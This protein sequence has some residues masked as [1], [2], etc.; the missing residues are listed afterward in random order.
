[1]L[2]DIVSFLLPPQAGRTGGQPSLKGI[3]I[4]INEKGGKASKIKG[5]P[6]ELPPIALLELSK[7]FSEG[8]EEYPRDGNVPNWYNLDCYE[9]LNHSGEHLLNF[10][11]ERNTAHRNDVMLE[12]LSH[13]AARALMA[14][15]QFIRENDCHTNDEKRE[16]V[17]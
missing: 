10:L 13:F 7:V 17:G 16:V 15:E 2:K 3:M 5:R 8:E 1:M 11:A 12:E 14:L 9:N 6:T 4:T